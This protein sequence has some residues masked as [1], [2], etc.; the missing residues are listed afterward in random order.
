MNPYGQ[1]VPRSGGVLADWQIRELAHSHAM[2]T[3][4]SEGVTGDGV[5]SYG[6]NDSG[7]DMR[8]GSRFFVF[9]GGRA[10]P[11]RSVDPMDFREADCGY[12]AEADPVG[13]FLLPARSYALGHSVES[14]NLPDDVQ[15]LVVG[16]STYARCGVLVNTT[17]MQAGW[18][19]VLTVEIANL[20]DRPVLLRCGQ[21]I[22]QAVFHRLSAPPERPYHLRGG[23]YQGQQGVTLPR[24]EVRQ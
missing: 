7:Y 2:I 18:Q 9:D 15:A 12:W 5:V 11:F 4:F 8:L 3:P 16:K 17:P 13:T 6:L 1:A 14:W 21:G 20:L 22:A 24:R 10:V 23:R 19:G